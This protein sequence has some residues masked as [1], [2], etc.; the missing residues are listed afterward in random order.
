MSALLS[1]PL[2]LFITPLFAVLNNE[3]LEN[4]RRLFLLAAHPG[5]LQEAFN[6]GNIH[7][8]LCILGILAAL[9]F[10]VSL[11]WRTMIYAAVRLS[12]YKHYDRDVQKVE[13][14]YLNVTF[15]VG[16]MISFALYQDVVLALLGGIGFVII[17]VGVV[18]EGVNA[19]EVARE[20]GLRRERGEAF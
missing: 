19:N 6:E 15:I 12:G 11:V 9:L 16:G 18:L 17:A 4:A 7:D 13:R 5:A 20:R 10:M 1:L 2:T 8:T 3:T 14:T